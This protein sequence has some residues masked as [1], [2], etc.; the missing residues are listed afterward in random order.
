MNKEEK[1]LALQLILEDLRGNWGFGV[2]ERVSAAKNI[3]SGLSQIDDRFSKTYTSIREYEVSSI[4]CGDWDGRW[5]RCQF[6]VGDEKMN[7]LHNLSHTYYDKSD[8]FKSLVD[9]LTYPEN[10]FDDW[11]SE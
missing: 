6:P 10:R 8:E 4:D 11:E 2:S 7:E 5:F 9:C 1:I 3:S